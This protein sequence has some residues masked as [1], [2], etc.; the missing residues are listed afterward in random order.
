MANISN[1][2]R[3]RLTAAFGPTDGTALVESAL[4]A[5]AVP[6]YLV[7]DADYP[8][9]REVILFTGKTATSLTTTAPNRFL[10]GSTSD[11]AV[12]HP[13]GAS[14]ISAPLKQHYDGFLTEL[15]PK[16]IRIPHT[17]AISGD[18][19]V[20]SGD[21]DFILPFFVPVPVGQTVALAS[22]RARINGGTSATI[23]VRKNGVAVGS[24]ATVTTTSADIAR[25]TTF[26]DGDALTLVV[27]AISGQPKNMTV[28]A[29]LDYIV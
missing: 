2:Y 4:A 24:T 13:A 11:T 25:T 19:K 20:P 18:V 1:F 16:T 12:I 27:T 10:D 23:E 9:R 28:T 8:E 3:T 22:L 7:I 17:W 21:V 15:P 29:Y 5:P 6:C 26:A 14:V